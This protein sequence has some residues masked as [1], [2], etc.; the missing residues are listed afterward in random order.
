LVPAMRVV[1]GNVSGLS[2]VWG[3]VQIPRG[4]G[5]AMKRTWLMAPLG[6]WLALMAPPGAL[7][8]GGPVPPVQSR[9]I[10]VPGS[11]SRYGAFEAGANTVVRRRGTNPGSTVSELRVSGH[12]GIPGV[13]YGG[14][15]TGLSADGR[16]LI[17]AQLDR[18]GPP[19]T[20]RLLVVDT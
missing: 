10:S 6:L 17:L 12:Y 7:A 11:Q 14:S 18:N 1:L 19:R 3:A 20:T 15:T 4:G 2:N 13:D 5:M 16:T 8:A 9:Y